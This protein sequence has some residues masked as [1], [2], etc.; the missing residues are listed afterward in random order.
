MM[1]QKIHDLKQMKMKQWTLSKVNWAVKA[2][3]EWRDV[4]LSNGYNELIFNANLSDLNNLEPSSLCESLCHFIPEVNK[5][6][7]EGMYPAKIPIS[8]SGC[9]PK[10]SKCKQDNLEVSWWCE[11]WK[12]KNSV[13]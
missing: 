4:C 10:A 13:R 6:K 2:Y 11:F 7:G 3:N 5:T 1:S 9:D 12:C 8:D